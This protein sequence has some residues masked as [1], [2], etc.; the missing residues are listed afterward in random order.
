MAADAAPWTGAVMIGGKSRRMG[1]DKALLDLGDGPLALVAARRLAEAGASEVLAVGGTAGRETAAPAGTRWLADR[2]PGAGPVG[3]IATALLHARTDV[4]VLACDLPDVPSDL[5]TA[6]MELLRASPAAGA[7]AV[8]SARGVE[9]M[10][11]AWSAN[12]VDALV[13]LVDAD[14]GGVAVHRALAAVA[15]VEVDV[16]D[17]DLANLNRPDDVERYRARRAG[18]ATLRQ[19]R[20]R[21]DHPMDVPEI[22]VHELAQQLAAGAPVV[23]VREPD[24]YEEV[25]VPGVTLIPLGAVTERLAEFPTDRTVYLV[26]RSGGRSAQAVAFLREQEVDAV[27]VAGGTL[28]WIESGREVDHG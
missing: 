18:V 19:S 26:C 16:P 25:R 12:A 8:R 7:A 10:V 22:D 9:P 3:G 4:M 15:A 21:E 2:W 17:L 13:A 27:N 5:V 6:V 1:R 24:E 23:D 20:G 28:A 11:S 14:P